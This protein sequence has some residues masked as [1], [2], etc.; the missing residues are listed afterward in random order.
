MKFW[1]S[2]YGKRQCIAKCP[3]PTG[4]KDNNSFWCSNC[5][6]EKLAQATSLATDLTFSFDLD[7]IQ[8]AVGETG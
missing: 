6:V 8:K 2:S 5:V 1:L 3:C 7:K 4:C